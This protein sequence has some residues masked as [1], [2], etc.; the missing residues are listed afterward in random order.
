MIGKQKYDSI[1]IGD[2]VSWKT[3]SNLETKNYGIVLG[4]FILKKDNRRSYFIR[5]A[6]PKLNR[7]ENILAVIV[8]IENKS[9]T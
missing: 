8:K 6:N 9:T 4:K 1:D 7:I 5:V 3:L 2:L